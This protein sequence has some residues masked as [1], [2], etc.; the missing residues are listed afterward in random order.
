[1][2]ALRIKDMSALF[3]SFFQSKIGPLCI[4]ATEMGIASIRFF[5]GTTPGQQDHH[6]LLTAC[7][8]SLKEYFQGTRTSF[9]LPLDIHGTPFQKDVW[10]A[11]MQIPYG[12]TVSYKDIAQQIGREKA[13]RAVGNANNK[14]N[15]VIV[16]PCHRVIASNGKLAG[17]GGGIWRKRWL[18]D[19]EKKVLATK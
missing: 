15:I 13:P 8:Q 7:S 18:L 3:T 2:P 14:N 1:M 11:L 4:T 6:P 12:Q 9:D 5:D 10:N 19:H 17:F 16:I